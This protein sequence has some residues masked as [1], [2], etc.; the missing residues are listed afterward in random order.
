MSSLH[1]V[2][3]KLAEQWAIRSEAGVTAIEY[4]LIAGVTVL[5]V[6]A[7]ATAIGT[8]LLSIFRGLAGRFPAV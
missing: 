3:S 1:H 4:A 5:T 7:G 6:V 2:L 8:S